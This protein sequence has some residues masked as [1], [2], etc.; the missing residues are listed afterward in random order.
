MGT[1]M[2]KK[3]MMLVV[4]AILSCNLATACQ[5][6]YISSVEVTEALKSETT[7]WVISDSACKRMERNKLLLSISGDSGVIAGSSY[8]W[9]HLAII[10]PES[11]ITSS[12]FS[13][14]T[15]IDRG[16]ASTPRAKELQRQTVR[17]AIK[18]YDVDKALNEFGKITKLVK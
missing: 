10:R 11:R 8:A 5:V 18:S 2:Q 9:A 13:S 4:I 1:E 14:A 3:T 16:D 12:D 6:N 17:N 15:I 7:A